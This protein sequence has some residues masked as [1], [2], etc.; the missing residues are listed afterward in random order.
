MFVVLL[1]SGG[2]ALQLLLS[3][4]FGEHRAS[5]F[6]NRIQTLE[7]RRQHDE[8]Q[9]RLAHQ[10][11]ATEAR[12]LN[13]RA[14]VIRDLDAA[15]DVRNDSQL[16]HNSRHVGH[17]LFAPRSQTVTTKHIVA[18]KSKQILFIVDFFSYKS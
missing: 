14:P 8:L 9:R 7:F 5:Y 15:L 6:R 18:I 10:A 16:V 11:R 1:R 4:D 12:T 13:R 2:G 3:V 17:L